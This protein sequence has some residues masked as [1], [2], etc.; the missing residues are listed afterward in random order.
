MRTCPR[1]QN[2]QVIEDGY[3]GACREITM[4]QLSPRWLPNLNIALEL[5]GEIGT[6]F[7][8]E[9]Q[10]AREYQ[11]ATDSLR[12]RRDLAFTKLSALLEIMKHHASGE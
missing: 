8:I 9:A 4:P 2:A 6:C 1:C 10:L 11:K 7:V 12:V 3:C 5:A